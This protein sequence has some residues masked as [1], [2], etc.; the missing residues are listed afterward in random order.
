M[1]NDN[2]VNMKNDNN[3]NMKNDNNVNMKNDNNVNMKSMSMNVVE[4]FI[5][6]GTAFIFKQSMFSVYLHLNLLSPK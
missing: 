5:F 6:R 3:V 1:K 2:N 4:S